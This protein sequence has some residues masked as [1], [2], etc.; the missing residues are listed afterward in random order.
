MEHG[1]EGSGPAAI[2]ARRQWLAMSIGSKKAYQPRDDADIAALVAANPLAW[3]IC[4][5]AADFAATPI[6]VQLRCDEDGRPS[7]LVGHFARS[8]PVRE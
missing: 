4:G 6:P 1:R 7:M 5:G 8:N 2:I 3:I